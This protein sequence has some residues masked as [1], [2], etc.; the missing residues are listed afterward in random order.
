[1]SLFFL[2][3][4]CLYF[5]RAILSKMLLKIGRL[6][7]DKMEEDWSNRG[8]VV[9]RRGTQTFCTLYESKSC[10][11]WTISCCNK[12]RWWYHYALLLISFEV[13]FAGNWIVK[14]KKRI[15]S[16]STC[17]DFAVL[18]EKCYKKDYDSSSVL[19]LKMAN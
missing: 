8:E 15:K 10:L 4:S 2:C 12:T 9:Y 17:N 5:I 14:R 13:L 3:L 6:K 16:I 19:W 11:I 7:K 1:M 18:G